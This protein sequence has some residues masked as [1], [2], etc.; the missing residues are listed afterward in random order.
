MLCRWVRQ[1][2]R[3]ASRAQPPP[4]KRRRG[5]LEQQGRQEQQEDRP[6][7]VRE[8]VEPIGLE[9]HRPER[10]QEVP[11]VTAIGLADRV[12]HLVEPRPPKTC[13]KNG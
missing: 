6:E 7:L 10:R 3:K 11:G 9:R 2:V 1:S 5:P 8:A 4:T 12:E 13:R